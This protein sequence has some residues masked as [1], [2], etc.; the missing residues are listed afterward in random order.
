[1]RKESNKRKMA[2]SKTGQQRMP[3]FEF[4]LSGFFSLGER[5]WCCGDRTEGREPPIGLGP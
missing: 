1:M 5:L 4:V 3:G 2:H